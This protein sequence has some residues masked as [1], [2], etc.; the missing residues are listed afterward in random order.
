[1]YEKEE[2]V[3]EK[4]MGGGGGKVNWEEKGRNSAKSWRL[5]YQ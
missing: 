2:E 3:K 1:L 4:I 5:T